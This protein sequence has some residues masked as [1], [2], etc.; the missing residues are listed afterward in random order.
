MH[1]H[2][3]PR[4]RWLT[5]KSEMKFIDLNLVRRLE[6]AS[7]KSGRACA[8]GAQRLHPDL[9]AAAEEIAGGIAVYAGARRWS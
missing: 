1:V 2:I 4:G 8:E 6:T 3:R 9:G 7:A 5:E